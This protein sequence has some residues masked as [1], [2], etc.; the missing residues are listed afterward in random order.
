M[1]L[2]PWV[3]S[4][5]KETPIIAPSILAADFANLGTEVQQVTEAGARVLHVDVMDGHFVPNI[6]IGVPVV[7][8]LRKVTSLPLDVHLMI[9]EP[10]KYIEA[11]RRA[12][13]DSL[14]IHIEVVPDPR[15]LLTKIRNLGAAPGLVLNPG[16]PVE[17][18]LPYVD[19]ADIIL[20]MSVQPG[21]GGQAFRPEVL[22]K[23]RTLKEHVRPGS[24]ISIDGGVNEDTIAEC[25][26][27]GVD[28][29]VA[30]TSVFDADDYKKRMDLLNRRACGAREIKH[31]RTVSVCK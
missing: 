29:F 3:E 28:M 2:E 15:D 6:S 11:F 12:G 21:F 16:T 14:L 27:A 31:G 30:G 1:K 5:A 13:A 23:V 8:S 17:S 22:S 4:L 19:Y 9:S 20:V 18:V 10:E 26:A 24:I 25:A 7:E